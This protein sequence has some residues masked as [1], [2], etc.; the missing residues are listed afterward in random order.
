[1]TSMSPCKFIVVGED[2]EENFRLSHSLRSL[3][4]VGTVDRVIELANLDAVVERNS[5]EPTVICLDLFGFPLYAVTSA[6]GSIRERY[7]KAV[8]N[9]YLDHSTYTSRQA[10]LP[11]AWR[12]RLTHYYKTFREAADQDLR[13]ILLASL[14]GSIQEALHNMNHDPIRLTPSFSKGLVAGE[15]ATETSGESGIVFL[16]YSRSDWGG[17]VSKLVR[18]LSVA[19]QRVWIDQ[20]YIVGGDD[21]IDAIGDALQV[22]DSLLLVLSPEALSSK[23][24]KMEYRH[25]FRQEKPIIPILWRRVD[26]LPFE[27]ASLHYVDFTGQ[28]RQQAYADLLETLRR[29]RTRKG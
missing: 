18:D 3:Y 5:S 16:S 20:D 4:G 1:M 8:F 11:D 15:T 27:L 29:Q 28:P 6:I 19:S 7:P 26:K 13:P 10:E 14:R 22:C 12:V 2:T 9:L 23:Y 17:F 25:F 21:W 24:V